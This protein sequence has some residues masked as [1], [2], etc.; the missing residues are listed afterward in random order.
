M[1]S[2]RFSVFAVDFSGHSVG[3]ALNTFLLSTLIKYV[4]LIPKNPSDYLSALNDTLSKLIQLGQFATMNFVIINVDANTAT[5]SS[6]GNTPPIIGNPSSG[7][8][9]NG[10]ASSQ[11]LGIEKS[12][13]YADHEYLFHPGDFFLYSDALIKSPGQDGL[14]ELK[15]VGLEQ[16]VCQMKPQSGTEQLLQILLDKFYSYTEFPL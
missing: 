14:P 7:N 5:Y 2:Y 4:H 8:V 11:P 13:F 15:N 9:I 16:W 6:A 12:A 3:S 1:D 10:E